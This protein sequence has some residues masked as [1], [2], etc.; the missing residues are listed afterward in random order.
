MRVDL[1]VLTEGLLDKWQLSHT[2]KA[3][4]AKAILSGN[5]SERIHSMTLLMEIHGCLGLLYP[6]PQNNGLKYDWIKL[7]NGLLDNRRP[8]DIIITEDDGIERVKA[9]LLQQCTY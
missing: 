9:L 8:I 6:E 2:D 5:Q 4:L 1:Q 7:R 3:A